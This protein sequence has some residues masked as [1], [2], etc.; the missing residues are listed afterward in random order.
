MCP[1]GYCEKG[2]PSDTLGCCVVLAG[3][4]ASDDDCAPGEAC[5]ANDVPLFHG[6]KVCGTSGELCSPLAPSSCEDAAQRCVVTDGMVC[7]T[8]VPQATR[9]TFANNGAVTTS[10][11]PVTLSAVAFVDDKPA[12]YA[13]FLYEASDGLHAGD[14]F[15][16]SCVGPDECVEHVVAHVKNATGASVD[17]T[18]GGVVRV[19]PV[20]AT[21]TR[22]VLVDEANAALVNVAVDARIDGAYVVALQRSRRGH[23]IRVRCLRPARRPPQGR[24]SDGGALAA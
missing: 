21:K 23:R 7:T 11:V 14:A 12:P 9:C 22:V 13:T 3:A 17:V 15:S 10:G 5:A 19:E 18:C 20:D 24:R 6:A 1:G 4:C 8:N 16:P 2:G